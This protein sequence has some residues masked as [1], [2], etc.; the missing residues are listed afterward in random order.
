MKI[1]LI[2]DEEELISTLA[3]RLSFRGI[4]SDWVTNGEEAMTKE[5]PRH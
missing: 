4:D 3:E 5:E 1:L 2:D